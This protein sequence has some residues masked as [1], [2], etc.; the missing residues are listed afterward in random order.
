M[1]DLYS[2]HPHSMGFEYNLVGLQSIST[3]Q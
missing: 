3:I 1:L 2:I